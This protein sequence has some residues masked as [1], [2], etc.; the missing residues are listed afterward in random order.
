[1]GTNGDA[2][3][4]EDFGSAGGGH[5]F[6]PTLAGT[7]PLIRGANL[8]ICH[9]EGPLAPPVGPYL[10]YPLFYAPPQVARATEAANPPG[11]S[12]RPALGHS[13]VGVIPDEGVSH[14]CICCD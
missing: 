6:L 7:T 8:A 11:H 12:G 9:L 10:G 5:D 3:T 4:G 14:R 13:A 2:P 1:V